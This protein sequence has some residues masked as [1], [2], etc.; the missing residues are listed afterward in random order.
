VIE[1]IDGSDM[2]GHLPSS[3]APRVEGSNVSVLIVMRTFPSRS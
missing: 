2:S 1:R 3:A